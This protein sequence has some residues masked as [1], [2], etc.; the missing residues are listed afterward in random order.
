MVQGTAGI[1]ETREPFEGLLAL[2]NFLA[3]FNAAC[4]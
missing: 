4:F 1:E 2:L 3:A